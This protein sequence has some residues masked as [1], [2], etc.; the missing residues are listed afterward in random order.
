ME[1]SNAQSR[2]KNVDELINREDPGWPLVQN[3]IKEAKNTVEVL[4][5]DS[6]KARESLYKLQVTTRSP[7]GSI[8]YMTGGI[9]VD[10][11]WIRILGS[12]C[13]TLKRT[14][15][16]WNIGKTYS[17]PGYSPG[18]LLVADDAIGGFFAINGGDLG[19][20]FGKVYYLAPESLEFEPLD[21]SYTEF[22]LFCF[23][24]DLNKFYEGLRWKSWKEDVV[25][26]KGDKVFNFY[27]PLWTKEGKSIEKSSRRPV[28]VE[29]QFSL[30]LDMRKQLGISK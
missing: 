5:V 21:L 8:V 6:L 17:A 19:K 24:G 13:E 28:P 2:L 16:D 20:D 11:G 23:S 26:L 12:G 22:I 10:Q 15:P 29:E 27:P 3:W 18:Y 4:P 25:K 9:L 30:T 7:M 14:L 1:F